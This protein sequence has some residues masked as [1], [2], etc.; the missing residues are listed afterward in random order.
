MNIQAELNNQA[1]D[2]P[3]KD[4]KDWMGAQDGF[5]RNQIYN[6]AL[7]AFSNC[8][9]NFGESYVNLNVVDRERFVEG[10]CR[11]CD[12]SLRNNSDY[13]SWSKKWSLDS[14]GEFDGDYN[15][16]YSYTRA[17]YNDSDY[18]WAFV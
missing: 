3:G 16:G 1:I 5:H 10:I 8:S 15:V 2:M 14:V 18:E 9:D 13:I 11:A 4:F 17:E 12:A 7:Q 6:K